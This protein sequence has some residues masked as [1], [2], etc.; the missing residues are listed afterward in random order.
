MKKIALVL[1][2]A[3]LA[4]SMTFAQG[5]QEAAGAKDSFELVMLVKSQGNG[6]FDA[7]YN[8]A[9]EAQAELGNVTVEYMGPAQTT[10][11][12]QIEIIEG[13]ISRGVDGIAIS[14]N[15]ADA[16]IPVC[17]KAMAAGIKVISFD[18]GINAGGR[19]VDLIPSN[20]SLI[21]QQQVQLASE[22]I[23]DAGQIA[24]LSA[25][26]QA[27][28]QN[29]WIEAMKVE[30]KN[31]PKMEL[32]E[33]VYG[34]DAPDKSY[35]E[36]NA[37]LQK[38]PN[39]KCI[40]CPTTVGLLACSQAVKDAGAKVEVTGLGLPSEMKGYILD[41]TCKQMALWNPIDLGYTSTY[42][43]EALLTGKATGADGT[44]FSCGRM[45][46]VN[47]ETNG[48]AV[49]GTPFV[50]NKDNIEQYAAIF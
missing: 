49:M 1:I 13:L 18:S 32:V 37:L 3:V 26:A 30:M 19:I 16:L 24:V 45:G 10:A 36:T 34:D 15:D 27:T 31:H 33:V 40:V 46:T 25:S 42:I 20:T 5:A 23:G 22:L 11:E 6:F 43:L 17:K 41:G 4:C 39:L 29:A 47:V 35:R 9:K 38:Y 12:G 28:N 21:G 14:A 8:G 48:I 7:C 44:S 2:V 50:F